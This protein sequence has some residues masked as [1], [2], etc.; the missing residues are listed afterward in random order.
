[1]TILSGQVRDREGQPAG[2]PWQIGYMDEYAAPTRIRRSLSSSWQGAFGGHYGNIMQYALRSGLRVIVPDLPHYGMSGPGNLDKSRAHHAGHARSR[3]RPRG[4]PARR[5]EGG[6]SGPL[7][8]RPA[9]IGY[10]LTW[11]DAVQGLAL[12]AP[13]GLEEYP[14][15]FA[16]AKEKKLRCSTSPSRATSTNEADLDQTGIL[17]SEIARSEQISAISTLQE[18]RPCDRYRGCVQERLFHERQ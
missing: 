12:E 5:Q 15:D 6:L 1:V 9:V 10:A 14:R 4:Q 7:A 13:A 3:V 11:P 18:A 8:R 16:I 2:R 17:A